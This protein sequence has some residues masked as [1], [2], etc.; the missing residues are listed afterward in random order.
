MSR[1][2][3]AAMIVL[4]MVFFLAS[5]NPVG[6]TSSHKVRVFNMMSKPVT[7]VI[8]PARFDNVGSNSKTSFKEIGEG[9]HNVGGDFSGTLTVS[10]RGD[11]KWQLDI[12]R[13]GET[14]IHEID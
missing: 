9:K 12:L 5:C 13:N 6:S 4:M 2:M 11:H 3:V 10:G 14:F 7:I 8:G 1:V